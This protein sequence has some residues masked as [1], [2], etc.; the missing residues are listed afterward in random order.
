[1]AYIGPAFVS[2]CKSAGLK[3]RA[4][5]LVAVQ[6]SAIV[7]LIAAG[8]DVVVKAEEAM[9]GGGEGGFSAL[10]ADF[11]CRL[12]DRWIVA[13]W[14]IPISGKVKLG[15][16]L[17]N[18]WTPSKVRGCAGRAGLLKPMPAARHSRVASP[19]THGRHPALA[20]ATA[21]A[22]SGGV[23]SSPRSS[24]RLSRCA[25]RFRN[26]SPKCFLNSRYNVF[27]RHFGMK[28]TWYVQS[29]FVWLRPC[30]SSMVLGGCVTMKRTR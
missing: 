17:S 4:V 24:I 8:V 27:R 19:G 5:V 12:L 7:D 23:G 29:H 2:G 18:C 1:M 9:G 25:V 6:I 26:N 3:Q 22:S 28:L 14:G 21:A 11:G 20:G 10:A 16:R 15:R 13:P 30:Y